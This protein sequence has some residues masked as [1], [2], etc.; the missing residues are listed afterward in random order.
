M[1]RRR[2]L[3]MIK[4]LLTDRKTKIKLADYIRMRNN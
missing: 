2:R 4:R 1:M 3:R